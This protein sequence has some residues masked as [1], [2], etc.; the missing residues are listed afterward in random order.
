[1]NSN[2]L[3]STLI[4]IGLTA[5]G[6]L[7]VPAGAKVVANPAVP[8]TFTVTITDGAG[9]VTPNVSKFHLRQVQVPAAD[10]GGAASKAPGPGAALV[11]GKLT[12]LAVGDDAAALAALA[13]ANATVTIDFTDASAGA[14]ADASAGGSADASADGSADA[15]AGGGTDV[16]VSLSGLTAIRCHVRGDDDGDADDL[17]DSVTEK[18][19]ITFS[20]ISFPTAAAKVGRAAQG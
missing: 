10:A 1:M 17:D 5:G 2:R 15:K 7:S 18:I 9:N 13:L 14:S 11:A 12:L 3:T 8:N 19:E 20:A 4:A 16:Q 6:L